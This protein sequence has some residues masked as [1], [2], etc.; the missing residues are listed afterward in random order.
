VS[1]TSNQRKAESYR[2]G[3]IQAA[4]IISADPERYPGL[5]QEWAHRVLNPPAERTAPAIRRA[6]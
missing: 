6:A 2:A 1:M 4:K 5:M 3:N